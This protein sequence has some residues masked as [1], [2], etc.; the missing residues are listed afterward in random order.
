MGHVSMAT[1]SVLVIVEREGAE[2][3]EKGRTP[4][5]SLLLHHPLLQLVKQNFR[6][7]AKSGNPLGLRTGKVVQ[8][9]PRCQ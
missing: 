2:A 7:D 4:V 5:L 9:W 6:P 3:E 1:I 8:K